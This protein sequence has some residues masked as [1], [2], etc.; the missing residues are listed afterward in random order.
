MKRKN[1]KNKR[2]RESEKDTYIYIEIRKD[3]EMNRRE[4]DIQRFFWD[5]SSDDAVVRKA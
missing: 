3:S 5:N 4:F 1:E 2:E